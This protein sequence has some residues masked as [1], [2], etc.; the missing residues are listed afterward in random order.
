MCV[1]VDLKI[2][3]DVR[4]A[5]FAIDVTAVRVR[6]KI[7]FANLTFLTLLGIF[8][9]PSL[10]ILHL[11]QGTMNVFFFSMVRFDQQFPTGTFVYKLGYYWSSF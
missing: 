7:C 6:P 10:Y 1:C 3:N 4:T 5:K 2:P 8:S 9:D 11:H